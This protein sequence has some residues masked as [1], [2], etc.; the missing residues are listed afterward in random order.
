M[1]VVT[2]LTLAVAAELL[3][4]GPRCGEGVGADVTIHP[5]A[6]LDPLAAWLH[7]EHLKT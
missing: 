5:V 6:N 1:V 2:T 7:R 3:G 4:L